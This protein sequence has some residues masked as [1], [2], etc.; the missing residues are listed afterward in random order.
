MTFD[1]LEEF[2]RI[3]H[4][5]FVVSQYLATIVQDLVSRLVNHDN[6]KFEDDEFPNLVKMQGEFKKHVFGSPENEELRK[7]YADTFRAHHRKNRHHPE[8]H[9]NGID[10]MTLVDLIEMLMDWKAAAI[11][12][13]NGGS[14]EKSITLMSEKYKISPQLVKILENTAKACNM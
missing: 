6:S 4:H 3:Y 1:E 14:I 8:H 12:D 5:K 9:P 13:G 2:S 11:R 7:R 10:D